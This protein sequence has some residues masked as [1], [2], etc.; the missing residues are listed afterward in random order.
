MVSTTMAAETVEQK[1]SYNLPKGDATTTLDLFAE[2][3]GQHII[4]MV[5]KVRGVQTNA[6]VGEYSST[7][8]LACMLN[9][10]E[11]LMIKDADSG[12]FIISRR[13]TG[14]SP[15]DPH[16]VGSNDNTNPGTNP[17]KRSSVFSRAVAI[18]GLLAT[19][20]VDAQTA[21]TPTPAPPDLLAA[22]TLEL[23]PFIVNADRDQGYVA[24]STLAGTRLRTPLNEVGASIT[25]VTKDFM[26]DI[27]AINA[28]QLLQ[29]LGNTEIGG[30][31]GNY[32]AAGAT[33]DG[34]RSDAGN[35]SAPQNTNR[36]RGL[37]TASSTRNFFTS[38]IGFDEY[39]VDRVELV[40]GPNAILFGLGNPAGILNYN[41]VQPLFDRNKYKLGL[42]FDDN[43][44][45]R[46]TVDANVVIKPKVLALRFAWLNDNEQFKQKPSYDRDLRQYAALE[47]RPFRN[48]VLRI[49]GE[50]GRVEANRVSPTLPGDGITP[51]F[52][53]GQPIR[54]SALESTNVSQTYRGTTGVYYDPNIISYTLVPMLNA[55]GTNALPA[56]GGIQTRRV[57]ADSKNAPAIGFNAARPLYQL[58]PNYVFQTLTNLSI[59][60]WRKINFSGDLG[61]QDDE[62]SAFTVSLQ[63]TAWRDR[64]GL[65]L[66]FDQ[67]VDD[68][69]F[70]NGMWFTTGRMLSIDG[71]A[72][73][74][75]GSPNPN[76]RRPYVRDANSQDQLRNSRNSEARATAFLNYDFRDN[77]RVW[78]K[79]LGQHTISAL[80]S[81]SVSELGTY[82]RDTG[83][84][85]TQGLIDVTGQSRTG[86]G[87]NVVTPIYYVGPATTSLAGLSY[88][89]PQF[90]PLVPDQQ[91][92]IRVWDKPTQTWID[93]SY[94]T[95]ND[96][97]RAAQKSRSEVA[98]K[99]VSWK[100]DW[101]D[102]HLHTVVGWRRDDV[103]V[104]SVS[105]PVSLTKAGLD[106][107]PGLFDLP[108]S[109]VQAGGELMT[110]SAVGMVPRRLLPLPW[111]GE[112]RLHYNQSKNFAPGANRFDIF[113]RPVAQP[114]GKTRDIGFSIDLPGRKLSF[115]INWFE[116]SLNATDS[117]L[118]SGTTGI[119]ARLTQE[120]VFMLNRLQDAVD[121]HYISASL[122][123]SFGT[124][125]DGTISLFNI[126]RPA[127]STQDWTRAETTTVVSTADRMAKG[128]EIELT[129]NP[130]S[131]LRIAAN[132][133]RQQTFSTNTDP[134]FRAYM[135]LRE[136]QMR[137]LFPYP[138]LISAVPASYLRSDGTI[139]PARVPAT[140]TFGAWYDANIGRLV[141]KALDEEGGPQSEQREWRAN[142]IAN[143]QF[144]QSAWALLRNFNLGGALRWQSK[145]ALGFPLVTNS[146]GAVVN[147][148]KHP[149][150]S[151]ATLNG[152]LWVGYHRRLMEN[153]IGWQ[154]Q[155]NVR[156]AYASSGSLLP[157]NTQFDGTIA[158][159][160]VAPPRTWIL[161]NTFSF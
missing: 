62:L 3:S 58:V 158:S 155:L 77:A 105:A 131:R 114:N 31:E 38:P 32:S 128:L 42:R 40:R 91:F 161:T 78:G 45:Q 115:A 132:V 5:A 160:R 118:G 123:S 99:A 30:V 112:M 47:F 19:Q 113:N 2:V 43:G 67:Q 134:S 103:E 63:Q 22:A 49:N 90:G 96:W 95:S 46:V 36:V 88:T 66:A 135:A 119:A 8:A 80:Y 85:V 9:D 59:A 7:E 53:L 73:L 106:M 156:N 34:M 24:T 35:L 127:N 44:T 76:F 81:E 86:D 137:N 56:T 37:G 145:A 74:P 52:E 138:R 50:K 27:G 13:Q 29:Y 121:A 154:V 129:Y 84:A 110:W 92:T 39:N 104:F 102:N 152:D 98:S 28:N 133:A 125:P 18:L 87:R 144:A 21:A 109:G 150:Y 141:Q 159:M 93:R 79:W 23:S 157:I 55:N 111:G 149:Y 12:A 25:A 64:V 51:F 108:A 72:V 54:S 100:G 71:N 17:M 146:A 117:P 122:A 75:D 14:S 89:A 68:S 97:L 147:D 124:P 126:Q 153:K 10:T 4:F 16:K 70:N 1:R 148:V 61:R 41:T 116:N 82:S 11:L 15:R 140:E 94:T 139:D 101:L 26:N 60:D 130:T 120:E 48:T 136:P 65:E 69:H 143:Y 142:V 57:P 151:S 33:T 83:W 20:S 6:V 107:G